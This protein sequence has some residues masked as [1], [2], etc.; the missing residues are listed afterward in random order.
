M[1]DKENK[2]QDAEVVSA[3]SLQM[4]VF[5]LELEKDLHEKAEATGKPKTLWLGMKQHKEYPGIYR[6]AWGK[7]IVST[8]RDMGDRYP[9]ETLRFKIVMPGMTGDITDDQTRKNASECPADCKFVGVVA[10]D[11]RSRW[12]AWATEP[13]HGTWSTNDHW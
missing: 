9:V 10:G 11:F 4:K 8:R 2:A 12:T 6:H 13:G 5:K 3:S 1:S 7:A